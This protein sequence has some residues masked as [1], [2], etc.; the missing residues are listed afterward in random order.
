MN[1]KNLF[2]G[3]IVQIINPNNEWH[4]LQGIVDIINK[5]TNTA[6]IWCVTKPTYHYEI[7]NHNIN[8]IKITEF[9]NKRKIFN[10]K[11][12]YINSISDL[13]IGNLVYITAN[14]EWHHEI[15]IIQ[16]I[17]NNMAYIYCPIKGF[18][19][20]YTIHKNNLNDIILLSN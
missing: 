8:E 10:F 3:D 16:R 11:H 5:E 2:I 19:Y 6:Y 17:K 9:S 14:N 12:S 1:I 4:N 18:K 7:T 15:G 20:L 13:Q